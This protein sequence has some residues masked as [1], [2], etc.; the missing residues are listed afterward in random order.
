MSM[1]KKR[2]GVIRHIPF[3]TLSVSDIQ[4]KDYDNTSGRQTVFFENLRSREEVQRKGWRWLFS[5]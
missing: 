4:P 1:I 3:D 5:S 2:G